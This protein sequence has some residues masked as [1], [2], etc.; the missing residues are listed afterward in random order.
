LIREVEARATLAQ[1]GAW[2]RVSKGEV[3]RAASL[4]STRGEADGLAR[5]VALLEDG[6]ADA[7]EAR[8]TIEANFQGLSDRAADINQWSEDIERQ[9]QYLVH[10]LMLP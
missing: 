1:R 4:A 5:K 10:E 9:C 8:D 7:H 3:K 2:E 6:L